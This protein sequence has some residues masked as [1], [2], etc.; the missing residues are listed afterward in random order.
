MILGVIGG[1]GPMATAY[2]TELVVK[3]TDA[4]TDQEH[5]EMIVYS[6]PSVP[7]RTA[8]ILG[9]SDS[10]PV[11]GIVDAGRKLREWGADVIAM[12]CITAHCFHEELSEKIGLPIINGVESVAL[13]LCGKGV[14]NEGIM[15]TD[16]TLQTGLFQKELEKHGIKA[17]TPSPDG[18]KRVMSLI[19]DDIKTG[20]EPNMEN[21]EKVERELRALGAENV[22]LGCTELSL[23]KQK[24]DIGDFFTDAME[25]LAACAVRAVGK[26]VKAD[27]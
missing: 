21:F 23:I 18:Q 2:F 9:K 25:C 15:A 27:F 11:P 1:L 7:D 13:Y 16:G 4:S 24:H 12:P 10:S 6:V 17:I 19:Y 20:R 14:R 3:M 5:P 26:K 22:I 8:Y